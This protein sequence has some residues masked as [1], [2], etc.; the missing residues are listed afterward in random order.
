ML[1]SLFHLYPL[2][3]NNSRATSALNINHYR[4]SSGKYC[5]C[6]ATLTALGSVPRTHHHGANPVSPSSASAELQSSWR[7]DA[8]FDFE[9]FCA[10]DDPLLNISNFR[11][12]PGVPTVHNLQSLTGEVVRTLQLCATPSPSLIRGLGGRVFPLVQLE[13]STR[14]QCSLRRMKGSASCAR[15]D[16]ACETEA[17][18]DNDGCRGVPSV[19]CKYRPHL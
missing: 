16:P 6:S 7:G 1:C 3:Y 13:E 17:Q 8:T 5:S 10:S 9:R 4:R 18:I 19:P 2:T 15:A 14:A 12:T 11:L